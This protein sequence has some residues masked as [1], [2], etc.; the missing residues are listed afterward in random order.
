LGSGSRGA[1]P[2]QTFHSRVRLNQCRW[3]QDSSSDAAL[4]QCG[5]RGQEQQ[6]RRREPDLL[7]APVP[8]R[9]ATA[10]G[11]V[12]STDD[13]FADGDA[14]VPVATDDAGGG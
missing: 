14:G 1:I 9:A 12:G 11:Y 8:G 5:R 3:G 6:C 13:A 2:S 7:Y 10:F 4:V